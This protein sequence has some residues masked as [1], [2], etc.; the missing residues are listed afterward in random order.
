MARVPASD[1]TALITGKGMTMLKRLILLLTV[2]APL[3]SLAASIVLGVP[4]TGVSATITQKLNGVSTSWTG[5]TVAS[6]VSGGCTISSQSISG[7]II[8]ASITTPAGAGSGVVGAC[9]FGDSTDA[10]TISM[11]LVQ[12]IFADIFARADSATVGQGW[13]D[14]S[15]LVYGVP[16]YSIAS[17]ALLV[18]PST[19]VQQ[20]ASDI[21]QRPSAENRL[22]QYGA[23]NATIATCGAQISLWIGLRMQGAV[24]TVPT[25]GYY[26]QY[27]FATGA[28]QGQIKLFYFNGTTVSQ[29]GSTSAFTC[30]N[31]H[32]YGMSMSAVGASPTTLGANLYDITGAGTYDHLNPL[33]GGATSVNFVTA[34]DSTA[35]VQQPGTF[36]IAHNGIAAFSWS[37]YWADQDTN[38]AATGYSVTPL[39]N[40]SGTSGSP[41]SFWAEANGSL[42]SSVTV[43][44][45]VASGAATP[46]SQS[47]TLS[48]GLSPSSTFNL[49]SST[50]GTS[51]V[52]LTNSGSLTNP[53]SFNYVINGPPVTISINDSNI[54]CEGWYTDPG[55]AYQQTSATGNKCKYGLTLV[56]PGPICLDVDVSLYTTGGV[57]AADYPYIVYSA[58]GGPNVRVQMIS[59]QTQVC[60]TPIATLG[61][62]AGVLYFDGTTP[63]ND[64]WG[65][66]TTVGKNTF[67]F[68]GITAPY[69]TVT[70]APY[71]PYTVY[72]TKCLLID[73]STGA[74]V[75]TLGNTGTAI[76]NS[77]TNSFGYWMAQAIGCEQSY[78]AYP[79]AGYTL[80]TAASV[81]PTWISG[82]TCTTNWWSCYDSVHSRL[83]SG[84][85]QPQPQYVFNGM[86]INDIKFGVPS[87]IAA[88]VQ[89]LLAAE[90]AAAPTAWLVQLVPVLLNGVSP[91]AQA[92]VTAGFNAY[93]AASGDTR[94]R[95]L[96]PAAVDTF[97]SQLATG[98]GSS[99]I[100]TDCTHQTLLG[101]ALTAAKY[102]GM[103]FRATV[104][105]VFL[106]NSSP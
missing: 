51:V 95:L 84:L 99:Y 105:P 58:D 22:D 106:D 6:V 30:T 12:N 27:N 100:A 13:S 61:S 75:D 7:Q 87:Q 77:Q 36:T 47:V 38:T 25:A 81:P 88:R 46:S 67:R 89:G 57:A 41:T 32:S 29:V 62:H 52:N 18:T 39:G 31:G 102:N 74:G 28:G 68:T 35:G 40:V 48:A 85:F 65:N 54:H 69:A 4:Q 9:V 50:I 16:V 37:G 70:Q 101:G 82:G 19:H 66:G 72:A 14:I 3:P 45:T 79:G 96:D 73:D 24:G 15:S 53:P 98:C 10:A 11:T 21:L 78:S 26:T 93:V 103:L 64:S 1:S 42:A 2:L 23:G 56:N 90:R 5:A 20:Y 91:Y 97:W 86:G 80:T 34:T 60:P 44:P 55:N 59:G 76:S 71:G 83:V 92:Q 8:T 104:P 17:S 94:A 43:T 49:T 63:V 33:A